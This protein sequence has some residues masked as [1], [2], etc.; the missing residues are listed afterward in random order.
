MRAALFLT[1][2]L[3]L[4]APALAQQAAP[5]MEYKSPYAG[6]QND[7]GNAHR[8]SEEILAWAQK[9]VTEALTFTPD[10]MNPKL[11]ELKNIFTA[12]SWGQYTSYLKASR[13]ADFVRV[14][15]LNMATV[16]SGDMVLTGSGAVGGVYHWAVQLPLMISFIKQDVVT[17]EQ[18]TVSGARMR[19]S[20]QI[21][22]VPKGGSEGMAIESWSIEPDAE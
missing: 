11:N 2:A 16:S 6:E 19:L 22:R 4:S 14:E 15:R 10:N 8:T 5:W 21:G 9:N 13:A 1:T 20:I 18:R 3:L 7:V 17:N 12:Q